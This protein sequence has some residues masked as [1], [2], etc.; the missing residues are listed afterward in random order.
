[1]RPKG[2]HR[3]IQ[4]HDGFSENF[5]KYKGKGPGKK[6]EQKGAKASREMS[7]LGN[8]DVVIDRMTLS[9]RDVAYFMRDIALTLSMRDSNL[10][11][12]FIDRS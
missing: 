7:A 4:K 5:A 10:S 12:D 8:P 1:V 9:L 6:E 11:I 2:R 3:E